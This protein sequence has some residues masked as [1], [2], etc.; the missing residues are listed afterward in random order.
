MTTKIHTSF[1]VIQTPERSNVFGTCPT[2]ST[3]TNPILSDPTLFFQHGL[4]GF[5]D[6]T[7]DPGRGG[8]DTGVAGEGA[9]DGKI[10]R[11]SIHVR[12]GASGFGHK[13][14]A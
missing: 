9:A 8:H 13:Q 1:V 3:S 2:D 6:L 10:K 4:D 5:E 12:D 7:V 11:L 14:R